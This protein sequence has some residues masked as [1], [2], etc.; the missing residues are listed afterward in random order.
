MAIELGVIVGGIDKL[1]SGFKAIYSVVKIPEAERALAGSRLRNAIEEITRSFV[2]IESQLVRLLQA[3]PAD[4]SGRNALVELEGGSAQVAL[5]SMRG[6]CT[7]IRQI[8]EHDISK[9]LQPLALGADFDRIRDAFHQLDEFDGIL[10]VITQELTT[11]TSDEASAI[12]DLV[13]AGDVAQAKLRLLAAR[14]EVRDLRRKVNE[15]LAQ[16]V[17]LRFVL[18]AKDQ[19]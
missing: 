13:D 15:T 10:L 19:T 4:A 6:H 8:W 11:F 14:G 7:V 1:V 2:A 17:E 9:V 18:R 12:L 3:D 5:A 16:M